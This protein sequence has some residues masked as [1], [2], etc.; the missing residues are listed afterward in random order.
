MSR[1]ALALLIS[2]L[3]AVGALAAGDSDSR[4]VDEFHP[5]V[6]VS[7]GGSKIVVLFLKNNF[8]RS[9]KDAHVPS[10]EIYFI[11]VQPLAS[12]L[13]YVWKV[14]GD[15]ISSVFFHGSKSLRREV[16]SMYVLMKTLVSNQLFEGYSYS[17]MEFPIILEGDKLSLDFFPGDH[18]D[19]KLQNCYEGIYLEED[20]AVTCPYKSASGIKKYLALQDK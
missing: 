2:V 18:Q 8:Q 4:Y 7:E 11:Q 13:K 3:M 17:V 14:E 1:L 20:K 12:K 16:R 15:Q 10:G 9:I 6:V 5:S 19:A